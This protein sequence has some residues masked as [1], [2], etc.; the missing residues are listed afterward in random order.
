MI[1]VREKSS[2][3]FISYIFY[4][5]IPPEDFLFHR[6]PMLPKSFSPFRLTT[7]PWQVYRPCYP[8]LKPPPF[9]FEIVRNAI[10]ARGYA[11]MPME[12]MHDFFRGLD[13][14]LQACTSRN[15]ARHLPKAFYEMQARSLIRQASGLGFLRAYVRWNRFYCTVRIIR[16]IILT[17]HFIKRYLSIVTTTKNWIH[18]VFLTIVI[19]RE[20]NW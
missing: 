11:G 19:S 20:W 17:I 14:D 3:T 7:R 9:L 4:I 10:N 5:S 18:F 8:P 16:N 12:R 2:I 13:L 15:R 6:S 1:R